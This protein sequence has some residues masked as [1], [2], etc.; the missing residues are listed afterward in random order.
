MPKQSLAIPETAVLSDAEI[1]QIHA[2][3]DTFDQIEAELCFMGFK[4]LE[5]P[6]IDCPVLTPDLLST[7]DLK[8][9]TIVFSKFN[10]WYNYAHNTLARLKAQLIGIEAEKGKLGRRLKSEYYKVDRSYTKEALNNVVESHPRIEELSLEAQKLE[11]WI[12]LTTSQSE[13]L[14]RDLRTI[15]RQIELIKLDIEKTRGDHNMPY[16]QGQTHRR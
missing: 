2:E 12:V 16:R 7:V 11:Q 14:E 15:S 5:R 4:P 10:S 9:Y 6:Q 3:H 13:G 8:E 1:D